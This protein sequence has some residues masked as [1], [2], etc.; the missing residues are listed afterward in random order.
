MKATH[1]LSLIALAD[2]VSGTMFPLSRCHRPTPPPIQQ[3]QNGVTFEV[4]DRIED[5]TF[6][7]I[8]DTGSS[9][10]WAPVSDLQC[11]DQADGQDAPQDEWCFGET[12]EVPDLMKYAA[13]QMF[14]VQYGTGIAPGRVGFADVAVNGIKVHS[15]KIGLIDRTYENGCGVGSGVLGLGFPPLTSALPGTVLDIC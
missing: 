6:Y 5:Q 1:A 9:D 11:V 8:R 3:I 15:Q 4:E 7:V 14:C 12:F 10:L 2:R 13:N